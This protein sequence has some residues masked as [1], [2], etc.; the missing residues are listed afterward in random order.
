MAKQAALTAPAMPKNH[1]QN[2][3][4]HAHIGVGHLF[5]IGFVALGRHIVAPAV[6][7]AL[8]QTGGGVILGHLPVDL[9][10]KFLIHQRAQL[11]ELVVAIPGFKGYGGE[12]RRT[13]QG[14]HQ[15]V[16]HGSQQF[17]HHAPRIPAKAVIPHIVL[18]FS[19]KYNPD[20]R[21][22]AAFLR[23]F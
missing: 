11:V 20:S 10:D 13:G 23:H 3:D 16:A 22:S 12:G 18:L 1:F 8:D 5:E 15:N 14:R 17:F 6:S 2:A 21:K 7:Q 9:A 4:P 19:G